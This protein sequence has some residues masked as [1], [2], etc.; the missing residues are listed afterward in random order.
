L[1]AG[2]ELEPVTD[3]SSPA[4]VAKKIRE[5]PTLNDDE[6]A[7]LIATS[8]EKG[9]ARVIWQNLDAYE[10]SVEH[11]VRLLRGNSKTYDGLIRLDTNLDGKRRPRPPY[12]RDGD[13]RKA[14]KNVLLW[15]GENLDEVYVNGL[16]HEIIVE[17]S[18]NVARSYF[19]IWTYKRSGRKAGTAKI[20]V[21]RC[22]RT[23]PSIVSNE[24][25]E[26]V[27]YHELLHDLLPFQMH[28]P[29]F[30]KLES[31]WPG[32]DD[33]EA[34]LHTLGDTWEMRPELYRGEPHPHKKRPKEN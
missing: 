9:A 16:D 26:F 30:R 27:I 20:L 32:I 22:L 25:L 3:D 2:P 11:E 15:I 21:N 8:F 10:Q 17:W 28:S 1:G 24:M 18:P 5:A 12:D 6:R 19:G 7:T 31:Q 14:K 34:R 13:L 4:A 33:I 29:L 23:K